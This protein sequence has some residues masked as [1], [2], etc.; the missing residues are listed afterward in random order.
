MG[1]YRQPAQLIDKSFETINQ[2]FAALGKQM[3]A[4]LAAKQKAKQ[5]AAEKAQAK[6]DREYAA[7]DKKR[8]KAVMDYQIKIDNWQHINQARGEDW[9]ETDLT[10]ESQLKDNANH[11]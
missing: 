3:Q 9:E 7:F 1:T 11:Y 10:I 6:K 2:S 8:D 4:Q 5:L